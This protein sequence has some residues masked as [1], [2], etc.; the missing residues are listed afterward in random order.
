MR[1]TGTFLPAATIDLPPE[2]CKRRAATTAGRA[3]DLRPVLGRAR[4]PSGTDLDEDR[5]RSVTSEA[6]RPADGSCASAKLTG[7]P[8]SR[9]TMQH[10]VSEVAAGQPIAE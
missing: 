4:Q 10:A 7:H 3:R 1:F 2:G 9:T 6:A 5:P 8:F